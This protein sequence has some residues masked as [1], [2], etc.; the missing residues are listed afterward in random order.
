MG[1]SIKYVALFGRFL[2]PSPSSLVTLCLWKSDPF[3]LGTSQ[4]PEPPPQSRDVCYGRPQ[5]RCGGG[6]EA[7]TPGARSVFRRGS[8][9]PIERDQA[10][11][12]ETRISAGVPCQ[13]APMSKCLPGHFDIC[14]SA[15]PGTLTW[16]ELHVKVTPSMS[17]CPLCL[18]C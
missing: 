7:S 2:P 18:H 13:S 1:P 6:R 10:R 5:R 4:S 16:S 11:R 9:S 12:A 15:P 8:V 14:Q 3:N 17:K